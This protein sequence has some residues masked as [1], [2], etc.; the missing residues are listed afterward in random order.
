VRKEGRKEGIGR[1]GEGMEGGMEE[2]IKREGEGRKRVMEEELSVC[3]GRR[4]TLEEV[5]GV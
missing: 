1:E 3:G 4:A 2:G 5:M